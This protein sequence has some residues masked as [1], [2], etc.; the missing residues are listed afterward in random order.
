MEK[1]LALM[2]ILLHKKSGAALRVPLEQNPFYRMK[3]NYCTLVIQGMI[4]GYSNQATAYIPAG[5]ACKSRKRIFFRLKY[6]TLERF[7]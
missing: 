7:S 5:S 4:P 2:A 6:S 3:Q 1:L